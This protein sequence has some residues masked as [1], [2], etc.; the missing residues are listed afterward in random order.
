MGRDRERPVGVFDSGA[1]GLTVVRMLL[2]RL[3]H[4]RVVY[5]GD[6]AYVPYGPRPPEEIR[7]F[8]ADA[9]RFLCHR[10]AKLIVMG[11][12]M[13]SAM[14]LAESREA[15]GCPVLGTVGAGAKA[16]VRASRGGRI[17]VA[18]TEGTVNSGA[19]ERAVKALR[20]EAQVL[21]QACPLL[22]PA[23][24]AGVQDGLLREAV[25]QSLAPL[26][27]KRPD[28]V[29]LGCT[30]YP[31]IREEIGAFLGE[32]VELV[33]PAESLAAEAEEELVRRDLVATQGPERPIECYASGPPDS[34][35]LWSARVL[36]VEIGIVE[37]VDIH[38]G[39]GRRNGERQRRR[40]W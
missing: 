33:D 27:E 34:L 16:A 11:C 21:Q 7:R 28:T 38:R 6:T 15:A 18:A 20:P 37:Q 24:E 23:V 5:F 4:E 1:G 19:Y 17:G 35:R 13:S 32:Q 8:A 40:V 2:A 29:V 39:Q 25:A 31:L 9:C 12:N 30:H 10:G 26:R 3:P 22:V 36:G 14:A